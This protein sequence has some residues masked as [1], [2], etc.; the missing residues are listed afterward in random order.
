MNSTIP[1]LLAHMLHA[2][3]ITRLTLDAEVSI[4]SYFFLLW[5][6]KTKPAT[7]TQAS[8]SSPFLP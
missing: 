7:T 4:K 8:D 5:Q 2:V 3:D 6:Q 1:R